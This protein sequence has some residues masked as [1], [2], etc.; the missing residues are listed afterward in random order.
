[1]FKNKEEPE[2][3]LSLPIYILKKK[4]KNLEQLSA[5]SSYFY[6]T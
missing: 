5:H 1:M 4:K 3:E 2:V 6:S